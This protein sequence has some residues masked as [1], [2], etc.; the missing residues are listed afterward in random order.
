MT[1]PFMRAYTEL[2]VKTLPPARRARDRRH[3]GVHPL[4]HGTRRPTRRAVAKL[5]EDKRREAGDGFDGS[6]VAHPDLVGAATEEFDDVLGERPNQLDRQRDD[7]EVTAA[8]L[9]DVA[10]TE[11]S[12]PRGPAQRR[13]RRHPVHRLLAPRQRRRR[14]ST[15]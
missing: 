14:R 15:G 13:Q 12:A 7:V 6:W 8:D 11:P 4:A 1:V 10:A 9:L 2:L 3:G 5:R